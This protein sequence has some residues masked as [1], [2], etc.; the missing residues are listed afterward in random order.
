MKTII[1]SKVLSFTLAPALALTLGSCSWN[2]PPRQDDNAALRQ[3]LADLKVQIASLSKAKE[4]GGGHAVH[5]KPEQEPQVALSRLVKG[6]QAFVLGKTRQ[7]DLTEV[8]RRELLHGQ[9]PIVAVLGCADSRTTPPHLF[10]LG[11][12]ECFECRSAGNVVDEPT[13]ASMEYAVAHL[14]VRLIVILGHTSCGAVKA[15]VAESNETP[16]V[17]NLVGRIRPA[18][19]DVK[20]SGAVADLADRSA[21]R[22]AFRMRDEL[23]SRSQL[24]RGLN[25]RREL[26]VVVANYD[27]SDGGVRW[28]SL[29]GLKEAAAEAALPDP[30]APPKAMGH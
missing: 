6:N 14:G 19:E 8:R 22:H 29:D 12:G 20:Q 9:S 7:P 15:A 25:D 28:L 30:H 13:V 27:L 11:L 16:S 1:S 17:A 3:E 23:C 5:S 26:R 18:I 2:S 4:S 24:L 21:V 10:A